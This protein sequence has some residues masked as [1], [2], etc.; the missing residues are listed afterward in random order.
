MVWKPDSRHAIY[1]RL[2][3]GFRRDKSEYEWSHGEVQTGLCLMVTARHDIRVDDRFPFPPG[4]QSGPQN[5]T[6]HPATPRPRPGRRHISPLPFTAQRKLTVTRQDV[7]I[8]SC[9]SGRTAPKPHQ[10]EFS[11]SAQRGQ[12]CRMS[13]LRPH[14]LT[15]PRSAGQL[16]GHSTRRSVARDR[17]S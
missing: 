7:G 2:N 8:H 9:C 4:Q 1:R 15:Q 12:V 3:H 13:R 10:E 11:R 17:R 5:R 14:S 16:A 6:T